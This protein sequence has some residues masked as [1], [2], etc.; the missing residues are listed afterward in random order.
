MLTGASQARAALL[1]VDANEGVAEQTRRHAFLLGLLGMRQVALVL[2]KMDLVDWSRQ[3]FEAVEARRG[4][5][6]PAS[7]WSLSRRSR[8]RPPWDE[9]GPP[10]SS[11]GLV[12][13]S[14][15]PGGAGALQGPGDGDRRPAFSRSGPVRAG[16]PDDRGRPRGGRRLERGQTAS[17]TRAAGRPGRGDRGLSPLGPGR[18]RGRRVR[19]PG[20][21]ERRGRGPGRVSPLPPPRS[22]RGR[23]GEPPVAGGRRC[24]RGDSFTLRSTTRRWRPGSF[25]S[26]P[27]TTRQPSTRGPRRGPGGGGPGGGGLARLRRPGGPRPFPSIPE[28]GRFVLEKAAASWPPASSWSGPSSR[29]TP[30]ARRPG[31]RPGLHA[32]P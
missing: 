23:P 20:P 31:P 2:N 25:A 13:G 12:P 10:R 4:R 19:G 24:G 5:C 27:A 1:V 30:R 29:S 9:R 3:R 16:R 17:C 6:A 7:A 18:G 26:T 14:H 32:H 22:Q 28:T 15:G 8:S 21:G 11:P